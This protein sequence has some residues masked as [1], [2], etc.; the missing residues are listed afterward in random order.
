MD[1][2]VFGVAWFCVVDQDVIGFV[3]DK[4][5]QLFLRFAPCSLFLVFVLRQYPYR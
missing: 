5:S 3:W 4:A 1:A 2:P